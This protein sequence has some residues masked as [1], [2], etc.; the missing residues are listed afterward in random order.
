M[1]HSSPAALQI[2]TLGFGTRGGF[3]KRELM[4]NAASF[5]RGNTNESVR[6]RW[7]DSPLLKPLNGSGT[8]R[9]HLPHRPLSGNTPRGRRGSDDVTRGHPPL[10]PAAPWRNVVDLKYTCGAREYTKYTTFIQGSSPSAA[11]GAPRTT[12][13]DDA[14]RP[15]Q[16]LAPLML[17]LP[18]GRRWVMPHLHI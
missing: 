5:P 14:A 18:P 8:N 1:L 16:T 2:N 15:R 11:R 17:S 7:I 10:W 4:S 13:E 9:P 3:K 6:A 12:E